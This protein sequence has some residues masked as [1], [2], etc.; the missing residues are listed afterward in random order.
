MTQHRTSAFRSVPLTGV[1]YVSTEAEKHGFSLESEDWCNLGQG[2]PETGPL[3]GAPARLTNLVVAADGHDYAPVGGL[4]EL[5]QAVADYYNRHYRIGKKS[6]Y[7]YEN[8]A[9]SSGGRLAVT[10]V[11]ASLGNIHLGHFLPDYTA[12]EE[13]L[14]VFHVFSPIPIL[15]E[16]KNHYRISPEKLKQEVLGRGLSALLFSNPSNPTGTT[17]QGDELN[18]WIE[19]SRELD[20]TLI[21]DEFYSHYIWNSSQ[22]MVSAAEYVDDVETDQTI[23]IDGL[24]KNWRYPGFRISWTVGPKSIIK[25][26]TSAGSFLDGGAN[27]P[28]QQAAI[29]LLDEEYVKAENNA[30]QKIF[31]QKRDYLLGEL[32]SMGIKVESPPEGGFYIWGNLKNLKPSLQNDLEFFEAGL[33]HKI[34]SVPGHFFDINPGKRRHPRPSRFENHMRFSF[35]PSMNV[36]QEACKR[37]RALTA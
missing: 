9:I 14:D 1:I 12:Y 29:A 17:L 18:S 37:L 35:G 15:L 7:S 32:R 22:S 11:A 28:T 24:T 23:I 5:R 30:I 4:K 33:Q 6:Q 20:L 2:Q 31:S 36:L 34:I 26:I 3:P 10:R 27:R 19:M 21:I 16:A 8:V 25:A 13:L